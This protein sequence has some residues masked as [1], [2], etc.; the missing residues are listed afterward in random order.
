[1]EAQTHPEME[2]QT[3]PEPESHAGADPEPETMETQQ[4]EE[5]LTTSGWYR[6]RKT[7]TG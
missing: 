4:E 3:H 5:H 2:A 7:Q 1:M 6:T